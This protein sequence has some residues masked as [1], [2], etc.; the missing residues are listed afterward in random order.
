VSIVVQKY[1]GTSVADAARISNVARRIV[2]TFDD[3]QRVCAVVSACGDTT[4]DLT[5]LALEI[6]PHPPSREMDMLLSAGERISC[7]LVAM[8]VERL[9][10]PAVSFTGAQAGILTDEKHG[11]AE[12]LEVRAHRVQDAL[13]RGQIALVAGFQGVSTGNQVTTLGRGGS[14]TSAVALA[15]ALGAEVC[16]I[17]T[18][19]DGVY[20]ANPSVVAGA[21]R[22]AA[23]T[24]D[25]MLEL[26]AAGAQVLARRAVVCAQRHQI[27][28]R[29]CSSFTS[30]EGTLVSDGGLVAADR[31]CGVAYTTDEAVMT[32][33]G[34]A[35]RDTLGRACDALTA[36]GVPLR[37]IAEEADA[38][39]LILTR[40]EVHEAEE[41]LS[42]LKT[43]ML[44]SFALDLESARVTVVGGA[45]RTDEKVLRAV[46]EVLERNELPARWVDASRS[47]L[48]CLVPRT[49]VEDVVCT[50]HEALGLGASASRPPSQQ[51]GGGLKC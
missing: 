44:L 23:V 15:H 14:D 42:A 8:A 19:V 45:V 5:R 27:P 51:D 33:N 32:I 6:S 20:T 29:V 21:H 26:T 10:R 7:A 22:I 48:S 31:I 39:S 9:G 12:I 17:Y 18:D 3:G 35:D 11:K 13:E 37:H 30:A 43:S 47:C 41:V 36:A 2:E 25:E 16:E 24:F 40:E 49:R 4:D 50:L 1:G 46:C 38:L 34:G 28:L